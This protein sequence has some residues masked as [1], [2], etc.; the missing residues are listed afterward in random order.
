LPIQLRAR[1]L[2]E[3]WLGTISLFLAWCSVALEPAFNETIVS[4]VEVLTSET[5]LMFESI[6]NGIPSIGYEF[7]KEKYA[8]LAARAA[9]IKLYA[10]ARPAPSGRVSETLSNLF[11][12]AIPADLGT[13]RVATDRPA[14]SWATGMEMRRLALWRTTLKPE[15]FS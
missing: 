13:A 12:L 7:Q 6:P 10:E 3:N 4:E 15:N 9:T 5:E 8:A 2:L 1:G 14:M 11:S